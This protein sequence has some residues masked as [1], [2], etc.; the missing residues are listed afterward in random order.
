MKRFV[1]ALTPQNGQTHLKNPNCL[2]N[3]DHFVGLTHCTKKMKFSIKDIFSKCDQIRWFV[4]NALFIKK[5]VMNL[6]G[7]VAC[8]DEECK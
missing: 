8:I 5:R 1:I 4:K 6:T 7:K 3:F 2:S